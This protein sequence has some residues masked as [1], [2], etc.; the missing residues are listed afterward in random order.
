MDPA[1]DG[2]TWL[3]K[4]HSRPFPRHLIPHLHEGLEERVGVLLFPGVSHG[5]LHLQAVLDIGLEPLAELRDRHGGWA[6]SSHE[7]QALAAEHEEQAG[8][9]P[10]TDA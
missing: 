1:G 4:A 5:L 10:Y 8:R 2:L 3:S 9:E 7:I 6:A